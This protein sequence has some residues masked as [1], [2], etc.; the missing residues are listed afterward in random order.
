MVS[1]YFRCSS[2]CYPGLWEADR[3]DGRGD[4][5]VSGLGLAVHRRVGPGG[6]GGTGRGS[7]WRPISASG[8]S[9]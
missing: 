7:S 3:S 4:P 1:V 5:G 2:L 6:G 8:R 9:S